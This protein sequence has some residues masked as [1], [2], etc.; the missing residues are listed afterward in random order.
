MYGSTY[1]LRFGPAAKPD[2]TLVP[3]LAVLLGLPF[4]T[5]TSSPDSSATHGYRLMFMKR[6]RYAMNFFEAILDK[7][8]SVNAQDTD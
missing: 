6:G 7:R 5:G 2:R 8:T 3:R 1:F 4:P